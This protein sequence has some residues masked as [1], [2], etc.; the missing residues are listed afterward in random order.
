MG[1]NQ[2]NTAI[3]DLQTMEQM[4]EKDQWVNRIHPL[5]KLLV[6]VVFITIT[7]S[8]QKYDM[9]GLLGMLLY[10]LILFPA[11]DLSVGEA[12]RRLRI[13][14]PFVCLIGIANP[15]VDREII[16]TIGVSG[17]V[18]TMFTL[19]L[20]GILTVLASYILIA[21][22]S[23][24]KICYALRM[25]HLPKILVTEILL[26]Y[27]Y[28]HVLLGEVRRMQQAYS[29]RAPG[30]KGIAIKEWGSFAGLLLLRSMDRAGDVY[31]SMCLRGFNGEFYPGSKTRIKGVDIGY[32]LFWILLFFILRAVPVMELAGRLAGG[33]IR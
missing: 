19:M 16:P 18:I 31:E 13:V 32:A 17:G 24:T 27:R 21:T 11:A 15:F 7:V 30:Q 9:N 4:A 22:T 12:F 33:L 2:I 20:K 1:K 6:T 25:L 10:P 28:I 8:F 3:H 29:L 26:I 14:L 23:I 5:A